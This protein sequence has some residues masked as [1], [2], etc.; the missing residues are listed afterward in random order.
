[1]LWVAIQ[2]GVY[3]L[4][5]RSIASLIDQAKLNL[6]EDEGQKN[7]HPPNCSI[8]IFLSPI[9]LYSSECSNSSMA[10]RC[11]V[12]H[13]PLALHNVIRRHVDD[14]AASRHETARLEHWGGDQARP[15]LL[16][17]PQKSCVTL[18]HGRLAT[19]MATKQSGI[20]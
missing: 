13:F 4:T 12:L 9:F 1:M 5:L 11:I 2:F 17:N 6:Q 20:C 14:P 7:G 15:S 18:H 19:N 16:P 10:L 3:K 8:F